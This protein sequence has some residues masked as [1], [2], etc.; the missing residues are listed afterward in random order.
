MSSCSAKGYFCLANAR[1]V[2]VT[3]ASGAIAYYWQYATT[4][5]C[6]DDSALAAEFRIYARFS[7]P[8]LPDNTLVEAVAQVHF[9]SDQ[10][11]ILIECSELNPF[12]GHPSDLG[13]DDHV[14]NTYPTLYVLG[15]VVDSEPSLGDPDLR[16]CT[17]SAT[18]YVRDGFKDS[19]IQCTWSMSSRRW[20]RTPIPRNNT[21]TYSY[22]LPVGWGS[23]GS[24]RITIQGL[25]M[26]V[27][28]RD[29]HGGNGGAPPTPGAASVDGSPSKKRKFTAVASGNASTAGAQ[30]SSH[31]APSN[32]AVG[33]VF[34]AP[35]TPVGSDDEM[36]EDNDDD[37]KTNVASPV[38]SSPHSAATSAVPAPV[39]D[40]PAPQSGTVQLASTPTAAPA[41]DAATYEAFLRFQREN[42]DQDNGAGA[43]AHAESSTTP[44]CG[45]ANT[46]S[47]GR[48]RKRTKKASA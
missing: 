35:A 3:K 37:N 38:P 21:I 43:S 22:G 39:A 13:Y 23:A 34:G 24:F 8:S 18:D 2:S 26:S 6:N 4:L 28:P 5:R 33:R 20:Q 14:P 29:T 46:S 1:R 47:R 16:G 31:G 10:G 41:M 12:P 17:L 15:T 32:P 45:K 25:A 19:L 42:A 36:E 7:D 40:S 44:A 27:G 30:S 48:G 11:T 9:P